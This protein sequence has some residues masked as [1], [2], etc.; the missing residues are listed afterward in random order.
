MGGHPDENHS[1]AGEGPQGP[2]ASRT[3]Y[4]A[5]TFIYR[6]KRNPDCR[7]APDPTDLTSVLPVVSGFHPLHTR[8]LHFAW[9]PCLVAGAIPPPW[10]PQ[11]MPLNGKTPE[12]PGLSCRK[13]ISNGFVL[14]LTVPGVT[15]SQFP[16]MQITC[17]MTGVPSVSLRLCWGPGAFPL[18]Y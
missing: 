13:T 14:A 17:L 9:T 16:T 18:N 8:H 4:Y 1:G 5:L 2:H 12:I 15:E 6:H 10:D 3:R 11:P 7:P